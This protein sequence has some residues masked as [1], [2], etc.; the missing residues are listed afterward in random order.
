MGMEKIRTYEQY[1]EVLAAFK[2][3]KA[4]CSTN[5]L[6]TRDEITA[7]IE[8][9]KLYYAEIDGVLWFFVNEGYFYSANFYVPSDTPIRMRK[10]DMDVLVELTGNQTRYNEQW[11]RELIAAGY[12]K[13]DKRMLEWGCQLDDV[14]DYLQTQHKERSALWGVQGYTLRKAIKADYPE[15]NKLWEEKIG[16]DRYT[17]YRLTEAEQEEMEK[18]GRG[19]VIYDPEGDICAAGMYFRQNQIMYDCWSA[20]YRIGSGFGSWIFYAK[21]LSAYQEGCTR[22]LT[23]V[24]EDNLIS[25]KMVQHVSKLTGKFYWQFVCGAR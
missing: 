22:M 24:R 23:W 1:S 10:Q 2:K 21:L 4:R 7:L 19:V 17:V 3:D 8:A 16:K 11:E 5:K 25:S 20:T 6:M 9:G 15:M 18:Y 13:G 12:E 14:I